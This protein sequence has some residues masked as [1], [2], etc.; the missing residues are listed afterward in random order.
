MQHLKRD[1]LLLRKYVYLVSA[2]KRPGEENT[3]SVSPP[4]NENY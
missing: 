1:F 2:A 4:A 3:D